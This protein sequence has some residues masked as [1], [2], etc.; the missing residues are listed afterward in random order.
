MLRGDVVLVDAGCEYYRYTSDITCTWPADGTYTS[1]QRLVY[2]AVL[3]AHKGVI[4]ALKP[5]VSWPD[6]HALACRVILTRLAAGGL[7]AGDDV[8]AMLDAELGGVFMPH[9]L[10]HFLGLST[11]DVGGYGG[12]GGGGGG[13]GGGDGGGADGEGDAAAGGRR[14]WPA[15]IDRPGFRSLRTARVLELGMVVTVEPGCYFNF[16]ALL[17][18]ILRQGEEGEEGEGAGGAGAGGGKGGEE[19]DAKAAAAAA[20]RR[21]QRAFL[22]PSALARFR[23]FGGVRLED[24]VLITK[25]GCRSLTTVPREVEDV[26]AVMRGAP[27]PKAA[28][29]AGDA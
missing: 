16:E 12:Y 21:R 18:P 13:G 1:D 15:R 10:G 27:W 29:A 28:A 7:L 25:D 6:M 2:G 23:R 9:G 20:L 22:V 26:E 5:G 19:D 11:H 3:D 17:D 14:Q 24:N 8:E 4:A